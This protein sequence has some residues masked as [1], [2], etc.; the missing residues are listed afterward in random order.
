MFV[1]VVFITC[2]KFVFEEKYMS[3]I[4]I[5][6]K[7]DMHRSKLKRIYLL[8]PCVVHIKEHEAHVDTFVIRLNTV[9]SAT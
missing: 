6:K 5:I 8:S 2:Y 4:V 7:E 3:K 1:Y 9:N